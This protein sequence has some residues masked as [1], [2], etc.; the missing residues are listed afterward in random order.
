MAHSATCLFS[1]L[2]VV[3]DSV[4]TEVKMEGLLVCQSCTN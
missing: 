3:K 4:N 1:E 2:C